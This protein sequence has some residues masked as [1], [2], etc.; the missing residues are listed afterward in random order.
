DLNVEATKGLPQITIDYDRSKVARY[1]L[2]IHNL[3]QLVE[4]AFAGKTAGQ[5]FE[6]EKR[7]DIVLRL[8]NTYRKNINHIKNLMVSLPGG[9]SIPLKEVAHIAYQ[10]GPMQISREGTKR[11]ISIGVNVR[12]RDIDGLVKEIQ[13]RVDTDIELPPGYYIT[14]GGEFENLQRARK[15]LGLVVPIALVLIYILLYFAL[16]SL[17]QASMIYVAIPLASIGGIFS[18]YFRGIPFSI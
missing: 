11:R 15:R 4:M 12:G 18:L 9:G 13:N 8:E 1:G 3:N 6:G 16:K 5:V 14:Y 2:N 17:R 7:F 10:D